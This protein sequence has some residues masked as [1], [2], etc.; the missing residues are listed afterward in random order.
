MA[1]FRLRSVLW[2]SAK[3]GRA[4]RAKSRSLGRSYETNGFAVNFIKRLNSRMVAFEAPISN[5]QAPLSST[6]CGSS[7]KF[8]RGVIIELHFLVLSVCCYCLGVFVGLYR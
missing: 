8:G 4:P 1:D 6:K 5:R 3:I 7:I 2:G